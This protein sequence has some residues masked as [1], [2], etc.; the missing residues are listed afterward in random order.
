MYT[1]PPPNIYDISTCLHLVW[2]IAQKPRLVNDTHDSIP[3]PIGELTPIV[4]HI[5]DAQI[6]DGVQEFQWEMD[7]PLLALH[8]M[9]K[10]MFMLAQ[11]DHV[12]PL[13]LIQTQIKK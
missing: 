11:A 13:R 8:L 12:T 3:D 1:F 2:Q 6:C 9:C 10:I 5:I 4:T 7:L